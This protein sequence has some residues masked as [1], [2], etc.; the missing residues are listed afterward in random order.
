M[1]QN[2]FGKIRPIDTGN[3]VYSISTDD[4]KI[5]DDNFGKL[6]AID[7]F[8]FT[9][10]NFP[11]AESVVSMKLDNNLFCPDGFRIMT[12][13][14]MQKIEG[15]FR[16]DDFWR[17]TNE[18]EINM[19]VNFYFFTQTKTHTHDFSN[20]DSAY[21][22]Y[23]G[24]IKSG[25]Q[26]FTLG[27]F[28]TKS[29]SG[30]KVTKC[31]LNKSPTNEFT[32][33][34]EDLLQG[35]THTKDISMPNV[36]DFDVDMTGGTNVRG[37]ARFEYTPQNLGCFYLKIKRKM[38]N[39]SIIT[40]CE[41]YIVRPLLGSPSDT[42]LSL[43]HLQVKTISN[44]NVYRQK[45]IHF[46]HLNAPMSAKPAGGAYLL[47]SHK[48]DMS[49]KVLDLDSDM[50]KINEFILYKKGY[51]MSIAALEDGFV[52]YYRE[53]D[54]PH[55]SLVACYHKSG[56][57]RWS[58]II[59]NN[60]NRPMKVNEQVQFFDHNGKPVNGM[61]AMYRPNAGKLAVGRNRIM[62]I[63]SHSNN[64]KVNEGGFLGFSGDSTISMDI[65][66]KDILLGDAWGAAH[67]LSQKIVYDGRQFLTSA[68]GDGYPQQVL[69]TRNDGFH[70]SSYVDGKTN[71]KNR[72]TYKTDSEIIHGS[73]PGNGQGR[74][75]GRLGGLH[76]IGF[77]YFEKYAQVYAR[78]QCTS[79]VSGNFKAN[80]Q[81][82]IG[83]VFFDRNLYRLS[84][85]LIGVGTEV[86]L[87]HSAMYGKNIFI[88]YT[89]S[90]RPP[91]D[92][93]FLPND[94]DDKNDGCYMML[95]KPDGTMHT[96]PIQ[97]DQSVITNDEPITLHDG[98]VAWPF[99]DENGQLKIYYLIKPSSQGT[100]D[101]G[102]NGGR[103]GI[104][105][106][107]MSWLLISVIG[108]LLS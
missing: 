48:R 2:D 74:S 16:I 38:W 58:Q 87:I 46:G 105:A 14:D 56:I 89:I 64:F 60:G 8:I 1:N 39:G 66:G 10:M 26:K 44:S 97:L 82:E 57:F 79:G 73:F 68:L 50:N 91:E 28:S 5:G 76:T 96:A 9:Q 101:D 106:Y 104:S 31:V 100:A 52:I 102:S 86:N 24:V 65:T 83:V 77:K 95:L 35:I 25:Q 20:K 37:K 80:Q 45:K 78:K 43:G 107:Q 94:Y 85:H 49:L 84:T 61:Q 47:H 40:S 70:K 55:K 69:F 27:Q 62:L 12:R 34:G 59:M 51:P 54:N 41:S 23:G 36:I 92:D 75:C 11:I 17:L 53:Y 33:M 19:P 81:N 13:F 30:I 42:S 71:E 93:K 99:I 4:H 18:K 29:T 90:S 3:G 67:S 22:F 98:N 63:F 103:S 6:I 32:K 108:L 21:K 7:D 72:F 88:I 15:T